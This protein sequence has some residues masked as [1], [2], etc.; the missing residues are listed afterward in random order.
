LGNSEAELYRVS[1]D[2][3]MSKKNES[4]YAKYGNER[5]KSSLKNV[6]KVSLERLWAWQERKYRNG[7]NSFSVAITDLSI[8]LPVE[9]AKMQN[10]GMNWL[11]C[12]WQSFCIVHI[13]MLVGLVFYI[14]GFLLFCE[15]SS[16]K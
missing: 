2:V 9:F 13:L 5:Q 1:I 16:A 10:M 15:E 3:N 12:E 6:K 11:Q 8:P 7:G 4:K 14:F